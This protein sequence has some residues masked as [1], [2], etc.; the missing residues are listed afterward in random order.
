[1]KII[2]HVSGIRLISSVGSIQGKR[3]C[4]H[5]MSVQNGTQ[6]VL[7]QFGIMYQNP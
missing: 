5:L 7:E 3:C 4:Q 1:M 2:Y 6:P